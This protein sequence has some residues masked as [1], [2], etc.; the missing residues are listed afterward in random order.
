MAAINI[1]KLNLKELV[2]L[3]G[4]L[5]SAIVEA[6]SRERA[7]VKR[8]LAELAET[9]GF[10]LSELFGDLRVGKKKAVGVAKFANPENKTDTWTGRGRKPNWLVTRLKK[11]AKLFDFEI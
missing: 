10:S 5:Q 8:K 7:D 6:R 9:S 4:K 1:D 3:E 2:S 11:G